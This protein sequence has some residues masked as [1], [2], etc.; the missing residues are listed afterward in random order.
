MVETFYMSDDWQF[1][2]LKLKRSI[3]EGQQIW[4]KIC[5]EANG[6]LKRTSQERVLIKN[7][8]YPYNKTNE[9]H[10]FLKFVL[11]T[12]LYVFRTVCLSITWSLALYPQQ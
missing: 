10:W 2:T 8:T 5:V 11:A 4:R 9:M 12:E 7:V 6:C 3:Q 1:V